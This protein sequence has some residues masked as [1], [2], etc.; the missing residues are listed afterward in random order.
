MKLT[1]WLR[2]RILFCPPAVE[3]CQNVLLRRVESFGPFAN[4]HSK[5]VACD[6]TAAACI[7]RLSPLCRPCAVVGRV[8]SVI[9]FSLDAV[10]GTRPRPHVGKKVFK[11]VPPAVAHGYAA[12]AISFIVLVAASFVHSAP[13]SML[14]RSRAT[15][16]PVCL[17]DVGSLQAPAMRRSLFAGDD[18]DDVSASAT[19]LPCRVASDAAS[20]FKNGQIAVHM[21]CS[22]DEGC[23]LL[24]QQTPATRRVTSDEPATLD[25]GFGAAL[26]PALPECLLVLVAAGKLDYGQPTEFLTSEVF[27]VVG[28]T[29]SFAGRHDVFLSSEGR[30]CLEPASVSALVPARFVLPQI[31]G[32]S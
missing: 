5:T 19:T 7:V 13:D 21:P 17:A 27:E 32:L 29:G 12:T 23:G 8:W 18:C 1:K 28:V 24:M 2:E 11:R 31:Q 15:V 9:V 14:R 26:A 22:V 6:S 16:T 30:L 20:K 4:R 3:A 25:G 10:L